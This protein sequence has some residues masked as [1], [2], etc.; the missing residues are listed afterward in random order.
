LI[1]DEKSKTV[2]FNEDVLSKL[3]NDKPAVY[4][5]LNAQGENI[6]TGSAKRGRLQE[7]L[8]EY[9]P[10]GP[11]SIRGGIKVQIQQKSSIAEAEKMEKSIIS[12]T[13]PKFN[14]LGK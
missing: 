9:L 7:R 8:Q 3:P 2:S 11:E 5:I 10:G 6:Y 14:K 4:K 13:K 1:A 12:R